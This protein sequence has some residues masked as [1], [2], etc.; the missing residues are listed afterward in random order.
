MNPTSFK[1]LFL[2]AI[3]LQA[4]STEP[5]EK[6]DRIKNKFDPGIPL[7]DDA[8]I[9][10][11]V[12]CDQSP[13][14]SDQKIDAGIIAETSDSGYIICHDASSIQ[15]TQPQ[16]D[17]SPCSAVL[18]FPDEDHDGIGS[19][20]SSY[21]CTS[22]PP[23]TGF[24]L[25][26]NDNCPTVPNPSQKDSDADGQGDVCDQDMD[27]DGISN[28]TDCDPHDEKLYTWSTGYLDADGDHHGTGFSQDICTDGGLPHGYTPLFGDNC[29]EVAN[30]QQDDLDQDGLGDA[31][32]LDIDGDGV[33]N[34]K[35]CSPR[36]ARKYRLGD[37]YIDSD[38]DGHGSGGKHQLCHGSSPPLYYTTSNDDNC[39]SIQNPDQQDADNN[40]IGDVCDPD[41]CINSNDCDAIKT[42][43]LPV[44]EQHVCKS[45]LDSQNH[46]EIDG[47][48]YDLGE[49][50]ENESMQECS[51]DNPLAWS[52]YVFQPEPEILPGSQNSISNAFFAGDANADGIPDRIKVEHL[53]SNDIHTG[54]RVSIYDNEFKNLCSSTIESWIYSPPYGNERGRYSMYANLDDHPG[55]DVVIAL[56]DA[57]DIERWRVYVLSS[58]PD[59]SGNCTTVRYLERKYYHK[60]ILAVASGPSSNVHGRVAITEGHAHGYYSISYISMGLYDH[61]LNHI[62]HIDN[63]QQNGQQWPQPVFDRI[64]IVQNGVFYN[65]SQYGGFMARNIQSEQTYAVAG[66][67]S[68]NWG[69]GNNYNLGQDMFAYALGDYNQDGVFEVGI[70]CR[71]QARVNSNMV[72]RSDNAYIHSGSPTSATPMFRFRNPVPGGWDD[73]GPW[74][75]NLVGADGNNLIAISSD[76]VGTHLIS[77]SS[78]IP[79]R[80]L[81]NNYTPLISTDTGYMM[82]SSGDIVSFHAHGGA[83]PHWIEGMN[84][85]EF[86][87]LVDSSVPDQTT[88]IE[89]SGLVTATCT[90]PSA[91]TFEPDIRVVIAFSPGNGCTDSDLDIKADFEGTDAAVQYQTFGSGN[92][93]NMSHG[94]STRRYAYFSRFGDVEQKHFVQMPRINKV[95]ITFPEGSCDLPVTSLSFERS[96]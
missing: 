5:P 90:L 86:E 7:T 84:Q 12:H 67:Y 96:M 39:P 30:W 21:V 25:I 14:S 81:K 4:C 75:G 22:E 80:I 43:H 37:F 54:T 88:V 29:P 69:E 1:F 85:C 34:S 13:G 49:R 18:L 31:C 57:E 32:D 42:C 33:S 51:A 17:A 15:Y 35:D 20:D 64:V 47:V 92:E 24:S 91:L 16:K 72:W 76:H 63:R 73:F 56:H 93:I 40:G 3:L 9:G 94:N 61:T 68:E 52:T 41:Y 8:A 6:N 95:K 36:N 70:A 58:L 83:L 66:G 26:S 11:D 59:D 74:L 2:L 19:G 50:N 53:V 46:C 62:Q 65:A 78:G 55:D 28:T 71:A 60:V 45:Y 77:P 79:N 38:N 89:E 44:C 48:C 23:P 87:G 10:I 82:E 27:G